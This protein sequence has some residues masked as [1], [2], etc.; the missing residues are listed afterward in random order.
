MVLYQ[1]QAEINIFYCQVIQKVAASNKVQVPDWDMKSTV[2]L[3]QEINVSAPNVH[4]LLCKFL[5][6]YQ[7]WYNIHVGIDAA[8]TSGALTPQQNTQLQQAIAASVVSQ[9]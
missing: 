8:G 5:T 9:K 6:S 3:L 2:E 4:A 7:E 1:T